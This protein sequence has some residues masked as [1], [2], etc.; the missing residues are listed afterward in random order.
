[1]S[2]KNS[3]IA[4]VLLISV[5]FPYE[6]A[7]QAFDQMSSLQIEGPHEIETGELVRLSARTTDQETA[8]WI[9]LSP[10]DLDYEVVDQGSRLLFSSG[11]NAGEQV[12]V[13]L[14]AQQVLDGRIATRQIKRT[15]HVVSKTPANVEPTPDLP[16]TTDSPI[17]QSTY[18]AW[19]LI[20]TDA[21]KALSES[22]AKNFDN[23]AA[24][25]ETGTFLENSAIWNELA[26][27]NREALGVESSAWNPVATTLQREFQ[28]LGLSAP[29]QHSFHL[30]AAA[31]AIRSAAKETTNT[32]R[33]R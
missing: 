3:L 29:R 14:L 11:C 20:R 26:K 33:S 28:K 30:K 17:Y 25:C 19:S 13:L 6:P 23:L 16:S 18:E 15:I 22:V 4:F 12:T 1:M 31:A 32:R 2:L 5:A 24:K 9:V 10:D 27:R 7:G 8:L 21:A